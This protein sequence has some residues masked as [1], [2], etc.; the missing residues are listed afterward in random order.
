MIQALHNEIEIPIPGCRELYCPWVTFFD[1][2][3]A[4]MDYDFAAEC[5]VAASRFV[6]MPL[7]TIL[8]VF[9]GILLLG[10]TVSLCFEKRNKRK[11]L[12]RR[13]TVSY[14]P[15]VPMSL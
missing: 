2:H 7:I 5:A 8:C 10:M 4:A 3:K 15:I 12:I 1:L 13:E 6:L 9:V 11:E 14:V